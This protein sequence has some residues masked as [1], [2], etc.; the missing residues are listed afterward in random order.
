MT[1]K[2]TVDGT[3]YNLDVH[4]YTKAARIRGQKSFEL[5][6]DLMDN[7]RKS[8]KKGKKQAHILKY[9]NLTDEE[10]VEQIHKCYK[11]A[12]EYVKSEMES[13][14]KKR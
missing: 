5:V 3:E 8:K 9:D 12:L 10:K 13:E 6:S 14:L 2:L 7:H 11:E 1:K 4:Q